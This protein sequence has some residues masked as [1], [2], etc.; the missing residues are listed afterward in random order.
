MDIC[1]LKPINWIELFNHIYHLTS[2][3]LKLRKSQNSIIDLTN[4]IHAVDDK[5]HVIVKLID[6]YLDN[7]NNEIQSLKDAIEQKSSNMVQR[8]A[9]KLK[10]EIGNFGADK[11]VEL[12]RSLELMGKNNNLAAA[13]DILES[14]ES[15]ILSV[16]EQLII[17]KSFFT[18]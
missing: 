4:L 8:I 1:I 14:L 13:P 2:K 12:L 11:A 17:Q 10:S 7:Y 18:K 6:F 3:N 15:E 9:H 16:K 5:I